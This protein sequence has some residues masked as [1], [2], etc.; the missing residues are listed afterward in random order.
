MD[1]VDEQD[2]A[3]LGIGQIGNH[4]LGGLQHRPA[5][6]LQADA[7]VARNAGGE[8]RLAQTGRTIEQDVPERLAALAGGIDRDLQPRV[9][10]ALSDHVLH[11]LRTQI[12]VVFFLSDL[13]G[14]FE[15]GLAQESVYLG[16][17]TVGRRRNRHGGWQAASPR[18]LAQRTIISG[19]R[20]VG[21]E[22]H[23][24]CPGP[25]A[26]IACAA[27]MLQFGRP[28][29]T[30]R[31]PFC[32]RSQPTPAM[33]S[34]GTRPSRGRRHQ[35]CRQVDACAHAGSAA[36]VPHVELDAIHWLPGWVEQDPAEFRAGVSQAIAG[37][38]WVVDG[39]YTRVRDLVWSRATTIIWLNYSFR[40]HF[41]AS[42]APDGR[43]DRH[44]RDR[45]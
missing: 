35:R 14:R 18:P 36:G 42:R 45:F 38:R 26:G 44:A 34:A 25:V 22:Q 15:N 10:L 1:F 13:V 27:R 24:P 28:E 31:R 16:R 11:P 2:R 40:D 12:A 17:K 30:T 39:N 32:L 4:I 5:G 41:L 29:T 7:Q 37:P 20:P 6:D 19:C 43:A 21:V 3:F 23:P 33:P 9:D 8:R